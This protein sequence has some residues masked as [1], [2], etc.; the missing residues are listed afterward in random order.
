[1]RVRFPLDMDSPSLIDLQDAHEEPA[2]TARS[3]P[4]A[5][6]SK[7]ADGPEKNDVYHEVMEMIMGYGVSQTIRAI[8]DLSVA[9]HLASGGSTAGEIA[10]REGT[11][12]TTTFRLL[13]AGVGLGLMTAGDDGRFHAT[14]R[15][16]TLRKDAPR[17]LRPIALSF[18]DPELWQSWTGFVTSIRSGL[19]QNDGAL[20]SDIY[21]HLAQNP[22]AGERFSAAMAGA[23]SCWSHN[24]ADVIDTSTVR[25]AVDVGG[26]NGSL[27]RLLQQANPALHA[28]IFDRPNV[29]AWAEMDIARSGFSDRTEVVGGDFFKSVPQGDL[30]LL[31]FI[32]HNWDDQKCIEILRQCRQAALP[33]ARIA[34]IEFIV[35]DLT[36]PGRLA[37][38]DD[39]S[40]LAILG[41]RG[42]CLDE[43]DSLLT[44][45]GLRRTSVRPTTY[46]QKVIEAVVA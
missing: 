29:V 17:S 33:G 24:I 16:A 1:M 25:R 2:M 15:L 19:R 35:G 6:L 43:F 10:E 45:A 27:V 8:A 23:T 40:M 18:T 12:A 39:I 36:D 32:L 38:I 42:R 9:D 21:D 7:L 5:R 28:V 22:E 4:N 20:E 44:A 46:P 11:A 3:K 31:K 13:R 30:Y 37:T 41:G 34:I 14:E 26:A